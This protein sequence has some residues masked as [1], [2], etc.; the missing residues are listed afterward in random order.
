MLSA[1]IYGFT[2]ILARMAFDG[3][4]NGITVMFL[5]GVLP[6]P[7]LFI[8]LKSRKIPLH[9]GRNWKSLA[10]TGVFGVGLTVLLL[11]MSYSYISVGMATT[12]HFTYPVLVSLSSRMIFKDKI[13][14]WKIAALILCTLGIVMFI[15]GG[16][17]IYATGVVMSLLSGVTYTLVMLGIGKSGLRTFDSMKLTFWFNVCMAITS[18]LFGL[19]TGRL[20]LSL[21]PMA[22][23][24]CTVVALLTTLCA[25]PLLQRGIQ[26]VGES[27]AA[28]LS[29]LEPIT[30][31]VLGILVLG[32]TISFPKIVG[33]SLVIM[34]V[35][36]IA[37]AKS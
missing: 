30:G 17:T 35:L 24:L 26:L 16:D 5:R 1:A 29:T 14:G 2:P 37:L 12:L 13:G 18:G 33:C 8:I 28:I 27:T 3:G 22:W 31:V 4:A 23:F 15:D 34:S 21:A 10:V 6:L 19:A 32:E 20:G 11:Y 36:L 25:L 9:P 7:L